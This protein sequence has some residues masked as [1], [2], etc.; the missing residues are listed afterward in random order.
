MSYDNNEKK[1]IKY[2]SF[3]KIKIK[4]KIIK[5]ILYYLFYN[6]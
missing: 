1:N 5:L 3:K 2:F 6:Y 4:Y